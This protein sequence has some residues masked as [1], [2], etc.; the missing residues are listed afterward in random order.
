MDIKLES[1]FPELSFADFLKRES[2]THPRDKKNYRKGYDQYIGQLKGV[3]LGSFHVKHRDK[4]GQQRAFPIFET[5]FDSAMFTTVRKTSDRK[6]KRE[7]S[8]RYFNKKM[9]F[10]SCLQKG[11]P[12]S[13]SLYILKHKKVNRL[14]DALC[15]DVNELVV[16]QGLWTIKNPQIQS[17]TGTGNLEVPIDLDHIKKMLQQKYSRLTKPKEKLFLCKVYMIAAE[18]DGCLSHLIEQT[19]SGRWYAKGMNLQNGCT[20]EVRSICLGKKHFSY[21]IECCSF[22]VLRQYAATIDP[23]IKALNVDQYIKDR[24]TIRQQVAQSIGVSVEDIKQAFT[25]IGF[26][27]KPQGKIWDHKN[28]KEVETALSKYLGNK[29]DAFLADSFVTVFISEYKQIGDCIVKVAKQKPTFRNFAGMEL[30]TSVGKASLLANIYQGIESGILDE[31]MKYWQQHCG[32]GL[33]LPVHDCIKTSY[34]LDSDD[35][36]QHVLSTTGFDVKFEETLPEPDYFRITVF[37]NQILNMPNLPSKLVAEYQEVDG[38]KGVYFDMELLSNRGSSILG[39]LSVEVKQMV[40]DIDQANVPCHYAYIPNAELLVLQTKDV[41]MIV[42][43][44]GRG[45]GENMLAAITTLGSKVGKK[46]GSKLTTNV[47]RLT[48]DSSMVI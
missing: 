22:T 35:L 34:R 4:P 25:S 47:T 31:V 21:D 23:T 32:K 48:V 37:N 38:V 3:L 40:I 12:G 13:A 16:D 42:D 5:Q 14:F 1:I 39:S 33:L 28:R 8:W 20:R 26:F 17:F 6:A 29:V 7:R 10:F 24:S 45:F 30:D 19:K 18:N 44:Y 46:S 43:E 9:P 36:S 11:S 15:H 41:L 2:I 27:A